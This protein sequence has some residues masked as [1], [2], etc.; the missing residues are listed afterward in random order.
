M[1]FIT[2]EEGITPHAVQQRRRD[3]R[4]LIGVALE[5]TTRV[6]GNVP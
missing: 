3:R 2:D 4:A 1:A 5:D 6:A